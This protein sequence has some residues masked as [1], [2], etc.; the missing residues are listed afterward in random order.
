MELIDFNDKCDKPLCLALGYFDS[1]HNGHK[2]LLSKCV[3]S[4]FLPAV[5]TFKNN[6]QSQ[7]SGMKRQCYT[8]LERLQIFERIGLQVVISANF[9]KQFMNLHAVEFLDNLTKNL[10]IKKV[11]FGTDYTC[12]VR[13]EFKS[14]DVK[15]YF[16]SKNIQVEIVDLLMGDNGKVASREIRELLKNGKI[17]EVNKLLPYPFFV[18]GV[19]EKGRNVGGNVVGYPTAN[20]PFP[21]DKVELK[22]GVYKTHIYVDGNKYLGLTNVGAHPTFEDYNFNLESFVISFEGDLY[23]K[24]LKVEFLEYLRGV[25]KFESASALKKQ[26]DTDFQRVLSEKTKD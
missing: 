23:G 22:A 24:N 5:F 17:C 10:N 26:I 21:A 8:F 14:Q 13:A 16:E 1:V 6:P 20:I 11:V 3:R 19:V 4:D 25:F 18:S 9:D 15:K 7:I 12:G 2:M